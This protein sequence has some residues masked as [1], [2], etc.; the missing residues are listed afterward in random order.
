MFIGERDDESRVDTITALRHVVVFQVKLAADALRDF[1]MSPLSVLAFIVDAISKPRPEDSLYLRLML[2]GRRSDR[3]IN[4]FDE[5]RDSGAFTIDR[6][7]DELEEALR[8]AAEAAGDAPKR[9]HADEDRD[10]SR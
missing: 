4:L 10:S 9:P 2:L 3:L 8:S 6:A 1:L 7:V 5:H